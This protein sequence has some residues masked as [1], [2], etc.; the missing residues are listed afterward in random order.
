MARVLHEANFN[1]WDYL[2]PAEDDE[3]TVQGKEPE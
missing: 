2:D 3:R 1:P